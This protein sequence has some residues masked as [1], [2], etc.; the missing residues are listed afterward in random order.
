[1]EMFCFYN[2]LKY[3]LKYLFI[4]NEHLALSIIFLRYTKMFNC[5]QVEIS[6][7]EPQIEYHTDL[8]CQ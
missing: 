3:L 6:E 4:F 1:M 5:G 7:I 2:G 8:S